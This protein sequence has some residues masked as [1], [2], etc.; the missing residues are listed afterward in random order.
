MK[1]IIKTTNKNV[2]LTLKQLQHSNSVIVNDINNRAFS[3]LKKRGVILY[4]PLT[5]QITTKIKF[6]IFYTK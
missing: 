3:S 5:K 2:Y 4:N 6:D 1:Q